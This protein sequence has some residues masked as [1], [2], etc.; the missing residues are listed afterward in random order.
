MTTQLVDRLNA[1]AAEHRTNG[2]GWLSVLLVVINHAHAGL[3]LD[4]DQLVKDPGQ[5][6]VHSP[7]SILGE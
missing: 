6:G 3:P 4:A 1:F 7:A 5:P 2:K